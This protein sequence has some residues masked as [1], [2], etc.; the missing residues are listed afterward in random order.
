M[1]AGE[2]ST[3]MVSR[4]G[5]TLQE[6]ADGLFEI[7]IHKDMDYAQTNTA[8]TFINSVATLEMIRDFTDECLKRR[9]GDG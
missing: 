6:H 1:M 8:V 2:Y 4:D 9:R 3:R 5:V 7:R